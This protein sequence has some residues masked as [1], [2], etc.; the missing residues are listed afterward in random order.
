MGRILI[1][2]VI[3]SAVVLWLASIVI[4]LLLRVLPGDPAQLLLGDIATPQA[5]AA[6]RHELGLDRSLPEQYLIFVESALRGDLGQSIRAQ[7]PSVPYVLS[8]FPATLLL[9]GSSVGI[10]V[11]VGIPIGVL[12]ATHRYSAAST[13][14]TGLAIL[15]QSTPNYWLGLVLITVFAVAL[16]WLPTSGYGTVQNLILPS[17]TLAFFLLGLIVRITRTEVLDVLG[18][19]YVRTARAK[20]LPGAIVVWRHVLRNA[21]IAVLTVIGLQVGALL[22][23]AVI[24]ETVFAWPGLGYLTIQAVYQRDYPVVQTAVLLSVLIF[25]VINAF[26]DLLYVV[27]DPRVRYD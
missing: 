4:F 11:L 20:G 8:R 6:K 7:V 9:A 3:D 2:R 27:V 10:A 13:V 24:T 22:G 16:H 5:V 26:M 1:Q 12:S 19:D 18:Q 25:V 14:A 23:G 17:V 21:L 15:A